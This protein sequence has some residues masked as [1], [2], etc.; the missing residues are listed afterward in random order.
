MTKGDCY[1]GGNED[2]LDVWF[3]NLSEEQKQ[4]VMDR[5]LIG[6]GGLSYEDK[7]QSFK[8]HYDL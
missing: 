6:W 3:S 1:W 8:Q 2:L 4:Q 5:S 7:L